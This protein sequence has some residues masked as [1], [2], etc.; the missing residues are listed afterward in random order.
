MSAL[1]LTGSLLIAFSLR[2]AP[3]FQHNFSAPSHVLMAAASTRKEQALLVDPLYPGT[4]VE[5]MINIRNRLTQLPREELDKDW[6]E[7][8]RRLLWAGGLK[9]LPHAVPGKGYTG[10]PQ[11]GVYRHLA[12]M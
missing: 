9:D 8:R 6:E 2:S 11:L 3:S 1:R 10:T 7:V 12:L 5:R 4:A